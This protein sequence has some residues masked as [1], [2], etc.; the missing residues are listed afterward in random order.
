MFE[1]IWNDIRQQFRYGNALTKIIIVNIGFFIFVNLV[2]L[3]LMII[4]GQAPPPSYG[5]F[6]HFFTISSDLWHNL[7]HPWVIITHMFLHESF[8][9]IFWN[10][11]LLYWFGR[12]V[13]DLL[14]DWRVLP[15]YLLAGL[16]GGFTY[17]L[18]ANLPTY[19]VFGGY[20]LG[21]SAAVMGILAVAGMTAP[22]YVLHLLLIGPV[23][24][25]YVVLVLIFLD[26]AALSWGSNSGG[27]LA[28]LGGAAMGF[29]IASQLQRG[30]D[31][32]RPVARWLEALQ[33]WWGNFTRRR[34]KPK[35]VF[36]NQGF[37]KA[38]GQRR[39]PQPEFDQ[40]RLDAILEKIKEKGYESLSWEEKE[41]LF[42]ASNKD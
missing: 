10:M 19:W 18:L 1:S 15:I 40:E 16:A 2:R 27:S 5:P 13:G 14:G 22:D 33:N 34:R 25:K 38:K 39:K 28:H 4:D 9:H 26:V 20:A 21:A 12:I 8:W 29:V 11:L 36:K 3:V 23:R 7:T 32:T 42:K 41:F 35:V 31:L 24:L 37:N 6:I 30:N 17:V